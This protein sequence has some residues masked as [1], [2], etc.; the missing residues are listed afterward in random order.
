MAGFLEDI[1]RSGAMS[2]VNNVMERAI[3]LRQTEDQGAERA[4]NASMAVDRMGMEKVQNEE[5]SRR[6]NKLLE[7]QT[8]QE[9]R[10]AEEHKAKIAKMTR[11]LPVSMFLGPKESWTGSKTMTVEE[12]LKMGAV[13]DEGGVLTISPEDFEMFKAKLDPSKALEI[14]AAHLQELETDLAMVSQKIQKNPQDEKALAER[15][16]L[17]GLF[18]AGKTAY[19]NMKARLAKPE[20]KSNLGSKGAA[21]TVYGTL[22][23][24]KVYNT[25]SGLA[26][27]VPGAD[28]SPV[29]APVM[30]E[31]ALRVITEAKSKSTDLQ[32]FETSVANK[33]PGWTYPQIKAEAARLYQAS[34]K[35]VNTTGFAYGADGQPEGTVATVTTRGG[36]VGSR[37]IPAPSGVSMGA[38]PKEP[39]AGVT[40]TLENYRRTVTTLGVVRREFNMDTLGPVDARWQSF[41]NKTGLNES[42]AKAKLIAAVRDLQAAALK[43]DS[44]LQVSDREAIRRQEI[45]PDAKESI[46]TIM[47]KLSFIDEKVKNSS[48]T[49]RTAWRGYPAAIQALMRCF[50]RR[51]KVLPHPTPPSS[52][53]SR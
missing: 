24:E 13:K 7:I 21:L 37:V 51:E 35:S 36:S 18:D 5:N 32:A 34:P 45:D 10:A 11:R 46:A 39:T 42:E 44:G 47:G 30:G 53:S 2:G 25:K 27:I 8:A 19:D 1:G 4:F 26:R 43:A 48:K 49:H 14:S 50:P 20:D 23:G 28:G 3:Q 6:Q 31:D 40:A 17:A 16:R 22:D 52:K 33:N 12:G 29:L 41:K 9:A 15:Q 38:A